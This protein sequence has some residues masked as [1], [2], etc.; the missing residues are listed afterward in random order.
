MEGEELEKV[1]FIRDEMSNMVWAIEQIVPSE[2]GVG[3]HLKRNV[4]SLTAFEPFDKESKIRYVLGN[5]VPDNW[6]PF[7]P[8]QKE[9]PPGEVPKEIRLQRARMPQGSKPLS[10]ILIESQPTYFIEEEEVPRAGVIIKRNFQRT[11]WLNGKTFLW[12]GRRKQAG[13]GEGLA[14]LTFDQILPIERK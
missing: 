10:K 7:I 4:P 6:I 14:N 12:V 1:N 9:V 2:A 11:R 5:T 8:V 3:R 13:R